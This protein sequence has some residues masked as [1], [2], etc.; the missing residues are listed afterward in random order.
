[1]AL[2]LWTSDGAG[3]DEP[4]FVRV[5]VPAGTRAPSTCQIHL[6]NGTR[7]DV[8]IDDGGLAAVLR[9]VAAL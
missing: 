3:L 8:P 5:Q 1:M 6:A 9:T 2:G 7:V 4:R